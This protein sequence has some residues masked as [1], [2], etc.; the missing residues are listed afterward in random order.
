[1]TSRPSGP[2]WTRGKLLFETSLLSLKQIGKELGVS[3]AAVSQMATRKGW[4]RDVNQKANIVEARNAILTKEVSLEKARIVAI[5]AQMQSRVLVRHRTSIDKARTLVDKLLDQCIQIADDVEIF[6]DLGELL[7]QEDDRGRDALNDAY[8]K[9]LSLP[10]RATCVNT[11]AT[12]LKTLIMLERQAYHIEGALVDPEQDKPQ[13]QVVKGLD[14][15]MAK[16]DAVLAMQVSER[17]ASERPTQIIEDLNVPRQTEATT[18][19]G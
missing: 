15:I 3:D 5:S 10:E 9:V 1:M 4:V 6:E 14:T 13:A 8:R 11:L 17:P 16:F 2:D 12:A 7:R 19:A 18:T